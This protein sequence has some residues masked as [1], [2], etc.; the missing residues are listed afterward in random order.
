MLDK[1]TGLLLNKINELCA[2]GSFKIVEEADLLSCFPAKTGTDAEGVRQMLLY[3]KEHKLIDMKYAEEGVY[4]LCPLPE[5]RLYFESARQTKKD[6]FRRRRDI[7]LMTALG[8]FVGAFVGSIAVWLL[9]TY[10]F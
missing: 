7:V 4:C 6:S 8:A 3:L 2:E 10:V 5:G 1:R 9:I